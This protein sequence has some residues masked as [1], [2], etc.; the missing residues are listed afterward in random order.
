M[1]NPLEKYPVCLLVILL[2]FV[3]GCTTNDFLVVEA[4]KKGMTRSETRKTVERFGFT[5]NQSVLRPKSGWPSTRSNSI[6]LPLRAKLKEDELG[7]RI[8]EA[9]YF[10]VGHGMFGIGFLFVFYDSN[11]RILDFYRHQVN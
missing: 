9:D 1:K 10:P 4:L 6:A 5:L 7:C 3:S 8:T 2:I 11:G